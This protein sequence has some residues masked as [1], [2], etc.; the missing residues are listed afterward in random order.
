MEEPTFT[1]GQTNV[2]QPKGGLPSQE[3][4][5]LNSQKKQLAEQG[6][7]PYLEDRAPLRIRGFHNHGEVV[8]PLSRGV[9]PLPNG[10]F[11]ASK[12][13]LLTTY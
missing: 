1:F 8:S 9:G 3:S 2:S 5:E 12:W 6:T 7:C 13:G 11:M 10:L 4:N